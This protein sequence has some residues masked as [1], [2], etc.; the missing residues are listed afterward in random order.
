MML[1]SM[2]GTD[3]CHVR[4]YS[5]AKGSKLRQRML[6]VKFNRPPDKMEVADLQRSPLK[7]AKA[8]DFTDGAA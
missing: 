7:V 6:D 2:T 4:V 5:C 1:V 8:A 3:P